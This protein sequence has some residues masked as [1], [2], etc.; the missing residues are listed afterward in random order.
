MKESIRMS[1]GLDWIG[2]GGCMG[3]GLAWTGS[4]RIALNR[5][6]SFAIYFQVPRTSSI[7]TSME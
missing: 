2:F 5:H 7:S 3:F 4:D 6:E 1:F